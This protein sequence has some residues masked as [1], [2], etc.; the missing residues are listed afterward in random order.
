MLLKLYLL[1]KEHSSNQGFT[2][3]ELLVVI[4]IIGILSAIA[5]PSLLGQASKA[6]QSDAKVAIGSINR[7]QIAYRTE[8]PT[9]APGLDELALGL[10]QQSNNYTYAVEGTENTATV[11]ATARDATLKGYSG[12]NVAY[13][14]SAGQSAIATV[15]CEDKRASTILPPAPTLTPTATTP[16]AAAQCAASQNKL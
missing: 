7:A 6:K 15:L 9:F 16:D 5:I 13:T 14:N 3:I 12:G 2:L 1:R 8:N 4:I 11:T 10:P